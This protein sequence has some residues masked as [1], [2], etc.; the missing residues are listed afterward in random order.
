[1][2]AAGAKMTSNTGLI[3]EG[4]A[5]RGIFTAGVLDCLL[6]KDIYFPYVA[7]VSVG[8]SN[9]SGFISRQ[10]GRS[11]K[12][13]THENTR[14][15]FGLPNILRT[16]RVLDLDECIIK[17]AYDNFP[18]DFETF[19]KSETMW[20]AVV[21]NC[22]TGEAEYVHDFKDDAET[23][24]FCKASCSL[25]FICKPINLRGKKYL[26]GSLAD[27][28]PFQ[29]A[30]DMGCEKILLVLTKA[31]LHE[32]TDYKK[33]RFLVDMFYRRKYPKLADTI[34]GRKDQYLRQ[35][36]EIEK[37]EREGRAMIIKPDETT[38]AHFENNKE[39]LEKCYQD[40][41]KLMERRFGELEAFLKS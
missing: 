38:V 5:I 24:E 41:Y 26:D 13:L 25:P 16:G 10:K 40:A 30:L 1:M 31:D 4:G 35:M 37:M 34:L 7:G 19:H 27:S 32:A 3:L 2:P 23:L 9:A 29:R 18:Y 33:L 22:E 39:K 8:V 12:I 11:K 28:I 6:D 21:A 36:E 15:F 20:E 17:Y 14:T